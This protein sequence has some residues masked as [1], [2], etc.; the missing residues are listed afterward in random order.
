MRYQPVLTV[1]IN[2][3]GVDIVIDF[4]AD[5]FQIT[6][7]YGFRIRRVVYFGADIYPV[8]QQCFFCQNVLARYGIEP[9][10]FVIY[11]FAKTMHNLP[12]NGKGLDKLKPLRKLFI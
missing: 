7:D 8:I 11:R 5:A 10:V 1:I 3:V 4:A 12:P 9:P 6:V 2:A